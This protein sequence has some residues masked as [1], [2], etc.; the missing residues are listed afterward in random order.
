MQLQFILWFTWL[1]V[2]VLGALLVDLGS[3]DL[4]PSLCKWIA[5]SCFLTSLYSLGTT[6]FL[7]P[8]LHRFHSQ[9]FPVYSGLATLGEVSVIIV[10]TLIL[11]T[12]ELPVWLG[13]LPFSAV[14][15]FPYPWQG[16]WLPS[17]PREWRTT[18]A[19]CLS[20]NSKG[21]RLFSLPT[22]SRSFSPFLLAFLFSHLREHFFFLGHS[23]H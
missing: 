22:H 9:E 23:P 7:F 21:N 16:L 6:S 13:K 10:A 5:L 12:V 8:F 14:A 1:Q 19:Q 3:F 2:G 18:G 15:S 4:C 11:E 20:L 17:S